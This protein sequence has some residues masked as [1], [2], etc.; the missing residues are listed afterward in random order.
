M[1][2]MNKQGYVDASSDDLLAINTNNNKIGL[3]IH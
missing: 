1:D 3:L 2:E